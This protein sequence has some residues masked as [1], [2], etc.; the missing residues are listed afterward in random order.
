MSSRNTGSQTTVSVDTILTRRI[1]ELHE[2]YDVSV[3]SQPSPNFSPL[4]YSHHRHRPPQSVR[5][6]ARVPRVQRQRHTVLHD[7]DRV[8]TCEVP[9]PVDELIAAVIGADGDVVAALTL[10][11]GEVGGEEE[12][13]GGAE[14]G[15]EDDLVEP[16]LED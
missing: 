6:H 13:G 1:R 7:I 12:T 9:E 2:P 16:V 14:L 10:G 4:T 8:R 5:Q 3:P 15:D 11:G